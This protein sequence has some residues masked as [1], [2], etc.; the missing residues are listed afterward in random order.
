M[1]G[2]VSALDWLGAAKSHAAGSDEQRLAKVR[3][4]VDLA[5]SHF[6]QKASTVRR[7]RAERTRCPDLLMDAV[8]DQQGD[9][10]D[11]LR[12]MR[13]YHALFG[14]E[15]DG[16]EPAPETLP[17]FFVWD[18]YLRVWALTELV[19]QFPRHIQHSARQMHGWPMIVSHHLDCR[20][21]FERVAKDLGIGADYPLNVGQRKKRGTETPLLRYLEP[22]VWRLHI[23]RKILIETEESRKGEDFVSRIYGFWWQF[24]D[25]KPSPEILALLK[26]V[27]SLPP[28]SQKTA[29]EWSRKVIAPLIMID[30]AGT[31]KSCAIPALR[32]IWEHRAVKSRATFQSRLHSAVTD[33]LQRFGRPG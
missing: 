5:M 14:D 28:L 3:D 8:V 11:A 20:P 7:V 2:F 15:T 18:T 29:R 33:T 6:F 1:G 12:L 27:P 22:L 19:E 26:L 21:E 4:E 23:L 16:S 31:P 13:R 32:N 10:D 30:D 9:G 25:P 17:D 24:P